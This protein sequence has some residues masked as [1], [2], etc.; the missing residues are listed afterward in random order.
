M[1]YKI[2]YRSLLQLFS[3]FLWRGREQKK[4]GGDQKKEKKGD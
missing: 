1:I 4:R 2:R 3:L